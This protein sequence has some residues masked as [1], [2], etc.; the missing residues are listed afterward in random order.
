WWPCLIQPI[1]SFPPEG[2]RLRPRPA[3]CRM[4][5]LACTV[6]IVGAPDAFRA[7]EPEWDRLYA[8]AASPY[9][10][11]SF[12]WNLCS[13]ETFVQPVGGRLRCVVVRAQGS[14]V[15]IWPFAVTPYHRF[16]RVA[17]SL[18][19]GAGDYCGPL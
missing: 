19:T 16:W 10:T 9:L 2:V 5:A 1:G 8:R 12:E 6:E 7:L 3:G 18:A 4:N 11:Q 15:L 13:W 17:R 14:V